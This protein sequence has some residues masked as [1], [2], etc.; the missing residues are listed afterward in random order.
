LFD[1]GLWNQVEVKKA[2]CCGLLELSRQLKRKELQLTVFQNA[3]TDIVFLAEVKQIKEIEEYSITQE[4]DS[5]VRLNTLIN[6]LP[7]D[8][9]R[10]KIEI[11][12]QLYLNIQY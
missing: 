5:R 1:F 10:G 12:V 2:L 3:L 9:T 4:V 11:Y 6:N 8:E 7:S